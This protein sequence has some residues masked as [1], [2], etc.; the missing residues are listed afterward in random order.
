[1][2]S[3]FRK[4]TM[5]SFVNLIIVISIAAQTNILFGTFWDSCF[6]GFS[7]S[8]QITALLL[9][10][11]VF[12]CLSVLLT[13]LDFIGLFD[14]WQIYLIIAPIMTIGYSLNSA[15]I[16]YGLKTFDGGGAF[17]VFLYSGIFS[18]MIWAL[19]IRGK[20]DHDRYRIKES[21]VN[22]MLGFIGVAVSFFNWPVFNMAGANLTALVSASTTTSLQNS[23]RS[24]TYL[25]LSAAI[26]VSVLFASKETKEEKLKYNVYI[27]GFIN[28]FL[29]LSRAES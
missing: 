4:L 18:L 12:S 23:S 27:D 9:I 17:R 16:I 24:N 21:Y 26:L 14:Y 29:F 19:C 2:Y 15:I 25:G 28:V 13:V 10:K 5:F 1:M 6:N 7:S 11:T 20:I 3:A 22:K 8:F